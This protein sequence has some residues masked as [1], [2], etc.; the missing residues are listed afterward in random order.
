[1]QQLQQRRESSAGVIEPSSL[2]VS[3]QKLVNENESLKVELEEKR[4]KIDQLYS[5][6][7]SNMMESRHDSVVFTL[8]QEKAQLSADLEEV[9]S[10]RSLLEVS[11]K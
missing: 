7:H 3:I 10:K 4:S 9:R 1:M 8:Q 2:L 6:L 5:M 11:I